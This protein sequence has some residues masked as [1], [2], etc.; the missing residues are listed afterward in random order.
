MTESPQE[1]ASIPETPLMDDLPPVQPP[2][3]AFILQLFIFPALIV[4]GVVAVWWMFGWIAAGEQDWRKL[5]Q[6]LQSQNLHI[7]NRSMY[8]LAQVLDQDSRRGDHG[9]NLRGNREIAQGLTDQLMIELRKNSSS[10]EGVA[11]QEYLTRAL[12]ML[13]P[14]DVTAPALH[15]AM[16]PQRD[17]DIRK[18]AV[19]SLSFV[20]GRALERQEPLANPDSVNALVQLS[21]DPLPI[22]RQSSAFAL[23]LFRSPAATQQLQV[24]LGDADDKTRVNAAIGLSRQGSTAGYTVFRDALSQPT[25]ETPRSDSTEAVDQ[26][27]LQGEQF[28]IV[29]NVLK[30]VKELAEKFDVSQRQ[31]LTPIIESLSANH[32]EIRVRI[33]AADALTSLKRASSRD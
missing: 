24:L 2:S 6:D 7:R 4:I 18:S 23:G 16:E 10:K 29:K 19:V 11:I 14:L 33:D 28:L 15:L 3:A 26:A 5:L 9:Q 20:A 30:A 13:D 17:L 8:G 1:S 22:L 25:P 12:G 32:P 31:E 27:R 21:S